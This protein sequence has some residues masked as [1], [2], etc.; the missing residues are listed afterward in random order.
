MTIYIID[1]DGTICNEIFLPSG[2][3]DYAKAQPYTQRIAHI[4]QLYDAGNEIHYWTARGAVSKKDYKPL[5]TKQLETWG[6]KYHSLRVGGKPHYD[7]W[8][9]D[10]AIGSESFFDAI[11]SKNKLKKTGSAGS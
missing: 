5:T 9:D 11:D 10:K 1:I 3:K 4:N 7:L 6:C 2:S 8:V